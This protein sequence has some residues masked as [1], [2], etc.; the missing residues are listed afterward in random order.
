MQ[1][2]QGVALQP[3]A[4]GSQQR[5]FGKHCSKAGFINREQPLQVDWM[6]AW[7]RLELGM[8]TGGSV[9]VIRASLLAGIAA[10][11]PAAEPF[12]HFVRDRTA[13]L[14]GPVA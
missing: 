9:P 14:D 5:R 8:P 2:G 10:E 7:A 12:G 3:T 11:D 1:D 6:N 13:M 4:A